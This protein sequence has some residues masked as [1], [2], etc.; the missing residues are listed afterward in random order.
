MCSFLCKLSANIQDTLDRHSPNRHLPVATWQDKWK[1][2]PVV[3]SPLVNG[4]TISQPGFDLPRCSGHFSITSGPTKATV[5]PVKEVGPCSNWHVGLWQMP[6]ISNI[7][8][9]YPQTKLEGRLQRMHLADDICHWTAKDIC[10]VNALNN[11]NYGMPSV[12][13]YLE[14]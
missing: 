3:N 7:V 4:P 6:K 1:S 14:L 9:S 13:P 8:N 10:L 5:H 12:Y 2:T 11:D